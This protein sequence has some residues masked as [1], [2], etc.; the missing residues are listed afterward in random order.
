MVLS[1]TG[2]VGGAT[3]TATRNMM[4]DVIKEFWQELCNHQRLQY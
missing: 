2:D 4:F 3:V 1:A